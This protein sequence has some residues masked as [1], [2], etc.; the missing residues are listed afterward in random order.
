MAVPPGTQDGSVFTPERLQRPPADPTR[1]QRIR[2]TKAEEGSGE[3]SGQVPSQVNEN[4]PKK[5]AVVKAP[6]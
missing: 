1:L 6:R 4:F 5:Y 2:G 3:N